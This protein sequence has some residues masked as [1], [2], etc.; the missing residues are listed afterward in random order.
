[1]CVRA[2]MRVWGMERSGHVFVSSLV[3]A[4][5]QAC[6]SACAFFTARLFILVWLFVSGPSCRL[7]S[8]HLHPMRLLLNNTP[9]TALK[10]K[11]HIQPR[12]SSRFLLKPLRITWVIFL[13]YSP[14][15][16]S[17]HTMQT[18]RMRV[19]LLQT[20]NKHNSVSAIQT[21][22]THL[23]NGLEHTDAHLRTQIHCKILYILPCITALLAAI[24][25]LLS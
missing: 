16:N 14:P 18:Q 24:D 5:C 1:M 23:V 8:P 21:V 3:P 19:A 17:C 7:P 11:A 10:V 20:L 12:V 2:C 13:F 9:K 4:C 6:F 22:V 25:F 15:C